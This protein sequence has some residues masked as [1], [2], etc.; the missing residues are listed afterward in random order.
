[1]AQREG[2]GLRRSGACAA[3]PAWGMFPTGQES[4]LCRSELQ[5]LRQAHLER[6]L[7][8]HASQ[9]SH[10]EHSRMTTHVPPAG[11]PSTLSPFITN[12]PFIKQDPKTLR[13]RNPGVSIRTSN[14]KY[15]KSQQVT[16]SPGPVPSLWG[17]PT[18]W[19]R[20]PQE[21]RSPGFWGQ[22]PGGQK[23]GSV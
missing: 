15:S 7:C 11:Q 2:V 20:F 5:G 13:D 6:Q 8:P 10:L 12:R 1:M 4:L 21:G 9:T 17:M 23:M 14:S 16:C 22:R 3:C 19:L 18:A